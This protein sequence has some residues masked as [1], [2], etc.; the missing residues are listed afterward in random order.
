MTGDF[1]DITFDI[2]PP[3]CNWDHGYI[4]IWPDWDYERNTVDVQR[5]E[6]VALETIEC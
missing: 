6:L 1:E 4:G 2:S 3:T 5:V